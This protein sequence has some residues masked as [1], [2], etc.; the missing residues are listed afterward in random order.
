MR[1]FHV[2]Q[3]DLCHPQSNSLLCFRD[4]LKSVGP[5]LKCVSTMT[6]GY[7]HLDVEWLKGAGIRIGNTPNVLT[8]TTAELVLALL[9]ATSRRLIE[10]HKCLLNG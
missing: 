1:H 8:D 9:L 3:H 7:D 4:I 2:F 6:V 10:S 5:N